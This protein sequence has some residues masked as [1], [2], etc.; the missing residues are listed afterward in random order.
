MVVTLTSGVWTVTSDL[1][2][3]GTMDSAKLYIDT[4]DYDLEDPD[5]EFT[6]D[7]DP[8]DGVYQFILEVT[9]DDVTVREK[10][11]YFVD[12]TFNC[13]VVDAV[14]NTKNDKIALYYYLLK[15]ASAC[16]DCDKLKELFTITNNLVNDDC[17]C[18]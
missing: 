9:T 18:N 6:I 14:Y 16:T 1:I 2:D 15:N 10:S 5:T 11:C 8:A 3:W 17:G 12:T 7:S 4:D 13:N